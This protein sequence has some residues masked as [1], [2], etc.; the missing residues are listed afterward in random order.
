M[1]FRSA[2]LAS[3]IASVVIVASPVVAQQTDWSKRITVSAKGGHIKGNP[4][5]KNNVTE[6]MS[7]TCNHCANFEEESFLAL[8]TD[9]IK[10]GHVNFEVRNFVLNALD[11]S[12]ALLAR[13][14]G[15]TKFFGN[16]RTILLQQPT[17]LRKFN[18]ASPEVKSSFT[19]GTLAQRL[20]K[21]SKA[22][23]LFDLMKK[24]GFTDAQLN[25]CL[26]SETERKKILGMTE[27]A[28]NT[29]KLTGTPSFTVNGKTISRVHNWTGLQ[30]RLAALPQ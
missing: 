26:A 27:Y 3:A 22:A 14:G 20:T 19:S 24:R 9:Y 2:Y 8:N 7:Y 15:R 12:A 10:K 23:G 16:H 1:T 6:Y 25:A 30:P 18:T 17:W 29:L 4:L 13:C 11:L 21:A 5:A 28:A